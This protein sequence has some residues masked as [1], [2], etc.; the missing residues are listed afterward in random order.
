MIPVWKCKSIR[1][2]LLTS[3]KYKD[4]FWG[5]LSPEIVVKNKKLHVN[6]IYVVGVCIQ[7]Y[8]SSNLL[9][10]LNVQKTCIL[11]QKILTKKYFMKWK[12]HI[13]LK[14]FVFLNKKHICRL[15]GFGGFWRGGGFRISKS[16]FEVE[17]NLLYW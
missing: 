15:V 13:F 11:C 16:E 8:Y 1:F 9:I 4:K 10:L 7:G 12:K 14:A 2:Y 5:S 6:N 3:T 17:P